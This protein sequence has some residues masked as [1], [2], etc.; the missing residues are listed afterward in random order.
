Q[1]VALT[2]W[3]LAA[4]RDAWGDWKKALLAGVLISAAYWTKQTA[5]VLIIGSGV[6]ALWTCPKQ[7]PIYA[8]T[9][10]MLCGL[11]TFV[12]NIS[13]DGYFWHYIFELHQQH[14]FNWARFRHKTWMM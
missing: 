10:A 5:F 13:T 6:A 2:L 7:L 1:F 12:Y 4:L 9:I 14:A 3:A 8:A 11:G